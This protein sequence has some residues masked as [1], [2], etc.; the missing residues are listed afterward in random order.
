M[1]WRNLLSLSPRVIC[2]IFVFFL[3]WPYPRSWTCVLT[4]HFHVGVIRLW[5]WIRVFTCTVIL[6]ILGWTELSYN[7]TFAVAHFTWRFP[8]S[9]F[10]SCRSGIFLIFI[11]LFLFR[12]HF[13]P[14]RLR[15]IIRIIFIGYNFES[16]NAESFNVEFFNI[17]FLNVGET[18]H[19]TMDR[20]CVR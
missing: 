19:H 13:W 2:R 6:R 11:C 18:D 16:L 8:L 15:Y 9:G 5:F 12:C 4:F 20:F 1:Y 14:F 17:E 10:I 3:G 7:E